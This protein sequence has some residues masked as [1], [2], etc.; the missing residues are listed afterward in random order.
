MGHAKVVTEDSIQENSGNNSLEHDLDSVNLA[1]FAS[2][3]VLI[4]RS[5]TDVIL[6]ITAT[7]TTTNSCL[8]Y[9]SAAA[10]E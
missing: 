4:R 8:L 9:T 10:D 5:S 2:S 1:C 6:S 7:I 3:S